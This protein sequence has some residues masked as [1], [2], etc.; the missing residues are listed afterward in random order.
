MRRVATTL[1]ICLSV[2][3]VCGQN[4]LQDLKLYHD[5]YEP[6]AVLDDTYG[7]QAYDKLNVRLGGDSIRNCKG[8]ACTG[9]VEDYYTNGQLLHKGYYVEGQ[10]TSYKNYYPNGKT[11]RSYRHID[12]NKSKLTLFYSNGMKKSEVIYYG[13]NPI[14]WSDYYQNGT[15]EYEEAYN[16]TYEYY[17]K[18]NNYYED[19]KP[20]SIM[21]LDNKKKKIYI[22]T[23]YFPNGQVKMIG[24][25]QFNPAVFDYQKIGKWMVYNKDGSQTAEQM[26]RDGKME[27]EKKM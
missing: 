26:W 23:E 24:N 6:T 5:V 4:N 8:Y 11:E 18:K 3:T 2:F 13:S 9:Y 21:E 16:K 7:I 10:L 15:L 19:G 1:A 27:K 12:L 20:Q 14:K 17:T 22:K 25:I